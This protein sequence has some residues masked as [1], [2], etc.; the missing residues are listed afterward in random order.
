MEKKT[1]VFALMC[2]GKFLNDNGQYCK[3]KDTPALAFSP[4]AF[5]KSSIKENGWDVV[6]FTLTPKEIT[7]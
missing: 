5:V 4:S 6:E 2:N 3:K 1:K 7:K